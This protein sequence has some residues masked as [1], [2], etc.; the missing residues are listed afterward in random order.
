MRSVRAMNTD[1]MMNKCAHWGKLMFWV[2]S[3]EKYEHKLA[4]T[5]SSFVAECLHNHVNLCGDLLSIEL[6][7][8]FQQY[9]EHRA[10]STIQSLWRLVRSFQSAKKPRRQTKRSVGEVPICR[11]YYAL[12]ELE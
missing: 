7:H 2:E 11:G 3:Q 10:A 12:L 5:A 1:N 4:E 8:V 9:R 6:G